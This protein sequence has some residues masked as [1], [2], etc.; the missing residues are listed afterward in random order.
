MWLCGPD[1][2]PIIPTAERSDGL[3][4]YSDSGG[5]RVAGVIP[6]SP[7]EDANIAPG[8]LVT[9]VEG[10]TALS[11]TRDQMEQWID[12]HAE[13]ALVVAEQSGE[14]ALKLRAWDLVP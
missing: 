3:S 6:G 13:I 5:W 7:A 10:R 4:L 14:R 2:A 8:A 12:T 9:Q 1:T 11:W